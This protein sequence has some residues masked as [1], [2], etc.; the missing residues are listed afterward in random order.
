MVLKYFSLLSVYT[1]IS[2]V[3]IINLQSSKAI[4]AFISSGLLSFTGIS[5][6]TS[7]G[8]PAGSSSSFQLAVV[9]YSLSLAKIDKLV[10]SKLDLF[11]CLFVSPD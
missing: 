5:K 11:V 10:L 2:I 4:I 8:H 3:C 9:E 7:A 1:S 6:A